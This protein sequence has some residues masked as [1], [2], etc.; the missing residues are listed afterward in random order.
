[1]YTGRAGRQAVGKQ[2]LKVKEL[3]EITKNGIKGEMRREQ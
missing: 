3:N 2:E 1:M